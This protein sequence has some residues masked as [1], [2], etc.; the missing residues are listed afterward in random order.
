MFVDDRL[1]AI[2]R[3]RDW[4]G[5]SSD[6]KKRESPL[7]RFK[8]KAA[9]RFRFV[10]IA[11]AANGARANPSRSRGSTRKRGAGRSDADSGEQGP[12]DKLFA[13]GGR[14]AP[15]DISFGSVG[16]GGAVAAARRDWWI[17]A[18][19]AGIGRGAGGARK[20]AGEFLARRAGQAR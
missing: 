3:Q 14:T 10:R 7:S 1:R 2:E 5:S 19:C 9:R 18:G 12:G 17:G 8:D 4:L 15:A 6:G 11:I 16:R 20:I 13:G